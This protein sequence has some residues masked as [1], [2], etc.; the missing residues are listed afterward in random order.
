MIESLARF[1]RPV[2]NAIAEIVNGAVHLDEVGRWGPDFRRRLAQ[3]A[4][5]GK[6]IRGS[7]VGVGSQIFGREPDAAV[8]R[9]AAAMEL[10]QSFLLIHDDIMDEDEVRRGEPTV[11]AQYRDLAAEEH[12]RSARRFGESMAICAGDVSMLLAFE[13][14]VSTQLSVEMR[15][16]IMQLLASEIAAVGIAQMADV[17]NG[18]AP[19]DLTEDQILSVYRYKTGRYTFSLPLSLGAL[20][21]GADHAAIDAVASWGEIQGVIFQIRDDELGI[22][23]DDPGKP[24]GTDIASDKKTI[25]RLRFIERARGTRWEET[26]GY[27][28][29]T[30]DAGRIDEVREAM[31]ALGVVDSIGTMLQKLRDEAQSILNQLGLPDDARALLN[32]IAAYNLHR[33]F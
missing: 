28:G 3:F 23:Q 19:S 9:V 1:R 4:C 10:V 8:F 12:Y 25:H 14:I 5:R 30:I 24:V 22:M 11:F 31:G 17:A 27:F 32:E 29:Q 15:L 21:T 6:L 7:L 2:A 33:V 26:A 20:L 18:H 16:K 13:G